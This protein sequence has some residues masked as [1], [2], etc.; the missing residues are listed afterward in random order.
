MEVQMVTLHSGLM[1]KIL[2][3]KQVVLLHN[4][5]ENPITDLS[6]DDIKLVFQFL[7]SVDLTKVLLHIPQQDLLKIQQRLTP[8]VCAEYL[9]RLAE[10]DR[11]QVEDRLIS[12]TIN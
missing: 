7:D 6:N 1:L 3:E 11:I 4:K 9:N 5:S 10:S 8:E 12:T 2:L